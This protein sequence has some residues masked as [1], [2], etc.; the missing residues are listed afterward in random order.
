VSHGAISVTMLPVPNRQHSTFCRENAQAGR[1]LCSGIPFA[2]QPWVKGSVRFP[3]V[4]R[5]TWV[6]VTTGGSHALYEV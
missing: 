3:L 2:L 1:D 5:R 6:S 4:G